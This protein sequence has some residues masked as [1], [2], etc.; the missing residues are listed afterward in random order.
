MKKRPPD[1]YWLPME[2]STGECYHAKRCGAHSLEPVERE[3]A[4][5]KIEANDYTECGNC[6]EHHG[7]EL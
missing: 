4:L 2:E 1:F 6:V 7:L 3:L 5:Q